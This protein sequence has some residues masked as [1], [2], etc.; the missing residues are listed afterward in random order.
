MHSRGP[1]K[2]K[3]SGIRGSMIPAGGSAGGN[4]PTLGFRATQYGSGANGNM[5]AGW[6]HRDGAGHGMRS[7]KE[8]KGKTA[9]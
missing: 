7:S 9:R 2:F 8:I 1:I 4:P 3:N 5:N 6:R